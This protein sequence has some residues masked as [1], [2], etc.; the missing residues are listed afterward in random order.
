MTYIP[1]PQDILNP[2]YDPKKANY[3]F[4]RWDIMT[5]IKLYEGRPVTFFFRGRAKM[6]DNELE[7]LNVL[8]GE[9]GWMLSYQGNQLG[10]DNWPTYK[11]EPFKVKVSLLERWHYFLGVLRGTN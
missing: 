6:T 1:T 5:Q 4:D 11:L 10:L 3:L 8:L 9:S 7:V 2:A